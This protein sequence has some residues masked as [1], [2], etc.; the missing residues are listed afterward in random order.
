M[1]TKID[2]TGKTKSIYKCDR[3]GVELN[4]AVN[5]RYKVNINKFEANKTIYKRTRKYDLCKHCCA[6][7]CK[8]IE[9]G[10]I[11]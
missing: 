7:I 2:Y 6:L 3:C 5:D 4:T 9:R 11:K 8:I 1:L 10:V